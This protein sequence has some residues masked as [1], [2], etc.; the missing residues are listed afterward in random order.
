MLKEYWTLT[1]RTT[2]KDINPSITGAHRDIKTRMISLKI[3]QSQQT[4]MF[5]SIY[6]S[7]FD[8]LLIVHD[9]LCDRTTIEIIASRVDF[10]FSTAVTFTLRVFH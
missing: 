2:F 9:R 4:M 3:F 6:I 8:T 1:P 10:R 5:L 7:T